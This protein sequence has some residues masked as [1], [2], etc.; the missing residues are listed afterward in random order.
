MQTCFVVF[1]MTGI[2]YA[3]Y[4]TKYP[5]RLTQDEFRVIYS[6]TIQ[7]EQIT[8]DMAARNRGLLSRM[9]KELDERNDSTLVPIID[10]AIALH[11]SSIQL[12]NLTQSM[13]VTPLSAWQQPQQP[14]PKEYLLPTELSQHKVTT[15]RHQLDAFTRQCEALAA[16][17]LPSITLGPKGQILN[18][19]EFYDYYWKNTPTVLTL[20][21]IARLKMQATA[22]EI[23]T[24]HHLFDRLSPLNDISTQLFP[25]IT[26]ESDIVSEGDSYQAHAELMYGLNLT[27]LRATIQASEG[28]LQMNSHSAQLQ[29]LAKASKFDANGL[30]LKTLRV[31]YSY[32]DPYRNRIDTTRELVEHYFVRK[33]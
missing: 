7:T 22:I 15:W 9:K 19:Q 6:A 21:T 12:A 29:V 5:V 8:L 1:L 32:M 27:T 11:Q 2:G 16:T 24:L 10:Q 3:V 33:K 28:D 25:T 17:P 13:K 20:Y 31:R 18:D 23:Q 4:K 26:T 14:F 30:A